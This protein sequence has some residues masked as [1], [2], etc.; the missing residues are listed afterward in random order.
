M[1]LNSKCKWKERVDNLKIRK[2]QKYKAKFTNKV[3]DPICVWMLGVLEKKNPQLIKSGQQT[4]TCLLQTERKKERTRRQT[5]GKEGHWGPRS[6]T[7]RFGV[8]TFITVPA[9][10]KTLTD[11]YIQ[12]LIFSFS[13]C[14]SFFFNLCY[15]TMTIILSSSLQVYRLDQNFAVAQQRQVVFCP[16]AITKKS[17]K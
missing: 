4:V 15:M 7:S 12:L 17:I 10:P 1:C 2:H 14:L 16:F 13:F 11:R 9:L 3:W 8:W 5:A 6:S